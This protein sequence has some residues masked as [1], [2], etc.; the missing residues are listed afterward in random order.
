MKKFLSFCLAFALI[1]TLLPAVKTNAASSHMINVDYNL[2]YSDGVQKNYT[3]YCSL[4]SL[5]Y[6]RSIID[7]SYRNKWDYNQFGNTGEYGDV[8]CVWS[9]GDYSSKGASSNLD[10]LQNVYN[11][12]SQN[13][14]VIVHVTGPDSPG[15]YVVVIGYENADYYSLS[16]N[17]F[18]IIEI[19][20]TIF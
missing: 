11:Y 12:V 5:A 8:N 2:L 6:C 7:N 9:K 18:W 19:N 13:K 3:Y 17:N 1:F 4:L 15:H 14:P 16:F 10:L 20:R